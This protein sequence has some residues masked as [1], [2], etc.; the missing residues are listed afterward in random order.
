MTVN[1]LILPSVRVCHLS[2]RSDERDNPTCCQP[3]QRALPTCMDMIL[4]GLGL[5]RFWLIFQMMAVLEGNE[6]DKH[7]AVDVAKRSS[8]GPGGG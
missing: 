5:L 3:R 2:S 6:N 4:E 8:P 7:E 1:L